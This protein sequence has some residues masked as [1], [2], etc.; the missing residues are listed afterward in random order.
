[1]SIRNDTA[2]KH[3]FFF[4]QEGSVAVISK[5]MMKENIESLKN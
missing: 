1:M 4:I 2:V 3:T 5:R